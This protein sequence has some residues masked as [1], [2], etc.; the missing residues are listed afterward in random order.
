MKDS[1]ALVIIDDRGKILSVN[2]GME[3][4]F[5]Y[6]S[7]ELLGKDLEILLP[8]DAAGRHPEH[9]KEYFAV[10]KQRRMG[11]G[12]NPRGRHKNGTDFPVEID[13]SPLT[14]VNGTQYLGAIRRR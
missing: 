14:T 1:D 6:N 13:L 11:D 9:R 5:G 10:P 12:L 4:L 2:P 7:K 3:T 8:T